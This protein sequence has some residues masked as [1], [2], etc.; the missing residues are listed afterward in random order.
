MK[1]VTLILALFFVGFISI[2]AQ[3]EQQIRD[4]KDFVSY[5]SPQPS[6]K[7]E[8]IT[9][10]LKDGSKEEGV[11]VYE[12]EYDD[13]RFPWV[14]MQRMYRLENGRLKIIRLKWNK[15]E[16]L[17]IG[18]KQ[19]KFMDIK[20]NTGIISASRKNALYR[21]NED[22]VKTSY[23]RYV[24]TDLPFGVNDELP[25]DMVYNK[26]S[27]KFFQPD[28]GFS[29]FTKSFSKFVSDCPSLVEE[30]KKLKEEEPKKSI[31]KQ[32]FTD[33]TEKNKTLMLESLKKYDE[34]K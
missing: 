1:K 10:F 34:C 28:A 29:G 5:F 25:T 13:P 32:A 27:K 7:T 21:V 3:V 16:A 17:T 22:F 26:E 18:D 12:S 33:N 11:I 14:D 15:I 31:L 24:P 8:S 4:H 20:L 9:V 23:I 6:S 30:L 2:N 19:Y